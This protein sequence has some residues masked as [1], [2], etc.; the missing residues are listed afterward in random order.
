MN[1]P[2]LVTGLARRNLFRGGGALAA[3]LPLAT[4]AAPSDPDAELLALVVEYR[5]GDEASKRRYFNTLDEIEGQSLSRAEEAALES[6]A[7]RI[8]QEEDR[9]LDTLLHRIAA[10]PAYTE[11]GLAAK[12]QVIRRWLGDGWDLVKLPWGGTPWE[13][14]AFSLANDLIWRA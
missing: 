13:R 9:V 1:E 2:N 5:R 4:T 14:V 7:S 12:G 6:E 10:T 3:L 11:A 8:F